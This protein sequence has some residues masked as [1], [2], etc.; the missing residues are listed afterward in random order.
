MKQ[1]LLFCALL[2]GFFCTAE[3]QQIT[4]DASIADSLREAGELELAIIEHRKVFQ[5]DP[6][7]QN[8]LYN[9]ACILALK[10][11]KD[12]AF[13]Y[14]NI[15]AE[16]DSS[17]RIL[18]D[19]DF[20]YLI[21]DDRWKVVQKTLTTNMETKYGK[22]GQYANLELSQELWTMKIK[23]QAF[24]YQ[25]ELA[26]E[27]LGVKSPV[28]Q[29]LWELKHIINAENQARLDEIIAQHGWPKSSEVKGSAA[30]AAFLI[31]QHAG[32]DYQEKYLPLMRAAADKGEASWS[33]LAL[34]IDRVNLRQGKQQI[35]G[36]QIYRNDDG[37]YYVKDLMAPEYVNQRRDKV[38][39][40]PIEV[41]VKNWDIEWTIEQKEKKE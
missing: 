12:S 8:N 20:Y 39:L 41:Y 34:L 32:I 16:K 3:A 9:F 7:D 40:P 5:Q 24:Y 36:S 6:S 1:S 19:A 22:D 18:N 25:I 15:L 37:S 26:N 27:Q 31:V 2:I 29:A 10:N 13:H 38:G 28:Y 30:G 11:Q 23:D 33:S 17:V 21:G 4:N 35:Y 14:L